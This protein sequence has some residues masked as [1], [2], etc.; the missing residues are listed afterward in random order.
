MFMLQ[1]INLVLLMA[2]T[3]T[4]YKLAM[5]AIN[6]TMDYL[7]ERI[8]YT[9]IKNIIFCGMNIMTKSFDSSCIGI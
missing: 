3:L 5:V 9:T 8:I 7:Q 6:K 1:K 4:M 2:F